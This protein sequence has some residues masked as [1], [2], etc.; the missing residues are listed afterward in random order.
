MVLENLRHTALWAADALKGRTLRRHYDE[1]TVLLESTDESTVMAKINGSLNNLLEYSAKTVLFYDSFKGYGLTAFPVVNKSVIRASADS[2]LSSSYNGAELYQA[3]TSG[4]TG[5]PFKTYQDGNK[6]LRNYADTL[7]FSG[8]A[9][10]RTGHRL[11]YLKIWVKEKMKNSLSYRLQNIIP[12]DVI[13]FN[14]REIEALINRMEKDRSTFGLLGYSSALELI[15]RYL[16]RTGHGPVKADV[17]SIIAI[18]E[19]LN[20]NTRESLQKYFEVP[21]VSRYSN[22][23][24]GIIAQQIPG[25]NSRYLVNSASYHVEILKMDSDKPAEEGEP[26]RI[27]VTDMF[28]YAM[29]MIRYDTGDIGSMVH[30]ENYPWRKYLNHVEGRRLD[31][32]YDTGGNL[33]SSYIVYKNMWQ[34]TEIEQYQLIQ[35][36]KKRYT[37][38]INCHEPFT[39]EQKLID[40]FRYYLG[41]DADFKVEYV[42][43]IPLLSSGK[44]KKIVN[45]YTKV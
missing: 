15:C 4:S 7:Y 24:N 41:Q 12:V 19:T 44:R 6:K 37:I 10:Y 25:Q 45:N 28:N 22:L 26:G 1:I 42:S 3:I 36:D 17:K 27:V 9:G 13:L 43:E 29:P 30:D 14:E 11:V 8:L 21:A 5:T 23:E 34:Y 35:E 39:R 2:F 20:D 40:E 31:L 33:V 18:S 16:D 38:K 32:L